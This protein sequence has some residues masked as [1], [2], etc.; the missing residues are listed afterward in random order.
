[1]AKRPSF[2]VFVADDLGFPDVGAFGGEI[3][4]PNI[5]N[6]AKDGIRFTDFHAASACSP[7]RPMLLSGAD[8]RKSC[9]PMMREKFLIDR[10]YV[11][12]AGVGA[13]IESIKG[14][15]RNN[16]DMKVI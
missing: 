9:H 11:D 16:Q 13:M 5:D 3:K 2:L 7:T 12:I 4:T 1:M 15:R 8:N 14:S 10:L 6:L